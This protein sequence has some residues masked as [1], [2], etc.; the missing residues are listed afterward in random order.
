MNKY[1]NLT[2]VKV[3][4]GLVTNHNQTTL[5]VRKSL[6]LRASL[7]A[8]TLAL[9]ANVLLHSSFGMVVPD[10]PDA[11]RMI[12]PHG[13]DVVPN[14]PDVVPDAPDASDPEW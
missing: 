14:S 3:R 5:T 7:L 10:G 6:S 1:Q 9:G 2:G 8:L 4:M 12:V 13:P 11:T